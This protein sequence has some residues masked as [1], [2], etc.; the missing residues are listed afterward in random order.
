MRQ[1]RGRDS[2]E[3]DTLPTL[4][5]RLADGDEGA[6]EPLCRILSGPVHK[7]ASGFFPSGSPDLQDVVQ[8]TLIAV[9]AYL[10]RNRGFEGDLT[11]FA[12]T[13]ARNRCRNIVNQRARR[14]E[15]PIEPLAE[16]IAHPQRSPLDLLVE[17]EVLDLLQR[18]LDS[19]GSAC[20]ILLRAFYVEGQ[21]I[22]AIRRQMGLKTVQGVYYRRASC[23]AQL[24]R[25]LQR[26]L[27][28]HRPPAPAD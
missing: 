22:E 24:G 12:V 2:T 20:R 23:L 21:S 18:A 11:S 5:A 13:V 17:R 26:S 7:A 4:A 19:L 15:T 27:G 25:I 10:R 8:E 1:E 16:W 9:L 28:E 14:P 6:A 3:P